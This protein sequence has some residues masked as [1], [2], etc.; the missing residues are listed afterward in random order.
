MTLERGVGRALGSLLGGFMGV[1]LAVISE[2]VRGLSGSLVTCGSLLRLC[3]CVCYP[4]TIVCEF[5]DLEVG[6]A[7]NTMYELLGKELL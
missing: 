7:G 5:E 3:D 2:L 4:V 6:V 1:Y